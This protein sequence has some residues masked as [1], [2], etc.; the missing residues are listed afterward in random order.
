MYKI[1]EVTNMELYNGQYL[2]KIYVSV[3]SR[4]K[5]KPLS[6]LRVSCTAV[7]DIWNYAAF[8]LNVISNICGSFLTIMQAC[9]LVLRQWSANRSV[10][11]LVAK[12][13]TFLFH[14][15]TR[16]V[17]WKPPAY[18]KKIQVH[19]FRQTNKWT[20]KIPLS[21]SERTKIRFLMVFLG[22]WANYGIISHSRI[23]S[24]LPYVLY[25]VHHLTICI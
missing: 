13:F 15:Y 3:S 14:K 12:L 4:I 10:F 16:I 17:S 20:L 19:N 5:F 23:N 6:N 7:R 1:Y 8:L 22:L 11:F 24:P 9:K 21:S 25:T 18:D 2:V